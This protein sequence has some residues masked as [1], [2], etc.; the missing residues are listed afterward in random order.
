MSETMGAAVVFPLCKHAMT[1]IIRRL[2]LALWDRHD[3]VAMETV[4]FCVVDLP[5]TA[6]SA[7]RRRVLDPASTVA[8]S[9]RA[10]ISSP[11]GEPGGLT[12]PE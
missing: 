2:A 11:P 5:S 8:A 9:V 10:V 7:N 3:R 6:Y 1:G 12:S 4:G